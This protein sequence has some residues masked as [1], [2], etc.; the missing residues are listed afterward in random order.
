MEKLRN[1]R[2]S[3]GGENASLWKCR[4]H[5]RTSGCPHTPAL[6]YDQYYPFL[7]IIMLNYEYILLNNLGI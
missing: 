3:N 7:C 5:A 6:L 1:G 4:T 2:A